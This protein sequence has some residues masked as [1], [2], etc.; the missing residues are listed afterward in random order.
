[1]PGLYRSDFGNARHVNA[2]AARHRPYS[3]SRPRAGP[4][5]QSRWPPAPNRGRAGRQRSKWTH[6]PRRLATSRLVEVLCLAFRS[7]SNDRQSESASPPKPRAS[8]ARCLVGLLREGPR[9]SS[10]SW[11]KSAHYRWRTRPDRRPSDRGPNRA[12]RA[13]GASFGA[14]GASRLGPPGPCKR[15]SA[16]RS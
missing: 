7:G 11:L 3:L 2:L 5:S 6:G 16:A 1:M 10:V 8:R 12:I 4:S 15:I 14:P 9:Q 13:L